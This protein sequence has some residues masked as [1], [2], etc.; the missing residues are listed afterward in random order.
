VS[1]S[2]PSR[3]PSLTLS[4]ASAITMSSTKAAANAS[5]RPH[6]YVRTRLI[7]QDHSPLLTDPRLSHSFT[8]PSIPRP[9]GISPALKRARQP[10][11]VRNAITGAL[12]ASFAV[13][14][15]AYSISAVKQDNFDDID[16]EASAAGL[17]KKQ[18]PP[19]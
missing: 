9:Q 16:A 15:W 6:G 7:D 11:V 17:I 8:Q 18:P 19:P 12:I 14:V 10:Y 5:Y 3:D 1:F 13:G 2:S 4:L